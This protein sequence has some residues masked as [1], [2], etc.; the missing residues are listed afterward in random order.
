QLGRFFPSTSPA[1][2]K[3]HRSFPATVAEV[4][5]LRTAPSSIQESML[6]SG[7]MPT[8]ENGVPSVQY[9]DRARRTFYD[10]LLSRSQGHSPDLEC[11]RCYSVPVSGTDSHPLS[12]RIPSCR[13]P[14]NS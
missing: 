7:S 3:D 9:N 10:D 2:S 11:N 8:T 14:C 4:V 12:S 6:Q 13:H 5:L 1:G